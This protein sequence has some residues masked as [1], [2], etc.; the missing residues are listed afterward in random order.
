MKTELIE[1]NEEVAEKY[2]PLLID[3]EAVKLYFKQLQGAM[4]QEQF[5][6]SISMMGELIERQV[7]DVEQGDY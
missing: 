2:K 1:K 3:M 7:D 4:N 6:E 5:F